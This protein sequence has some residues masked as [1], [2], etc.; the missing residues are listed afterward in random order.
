MRYA[1][2]AALGP[3]SQRTYVEGPHID[4]NESTVQDTIAYNGGEIVE[5]YGGPEARFPFVIIF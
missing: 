1:F 5:T 2:F 3:G 4:Y